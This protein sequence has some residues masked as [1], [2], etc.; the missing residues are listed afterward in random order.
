M[1][2]FL[3]LKWLCFQ[4]KNRSPYLALWLSLGL[5][6]GAVVAAA[7]GSALDS[8]IPA[9]ADQVGSL[10]DLLI[11]VLLPFVL[12]AFA[13][14]MGELWLLYP[15]AF[16]KAFLV[17]FLGF[18]VMSVYGSAGWLIRCLL[19]FSECCTLPILILFWIRQLSGQGSRMTVTALAVFAAVLI[20]SLDYCIVSPFLANVIS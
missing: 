17:S 14:L 1:G 12:S 19:L 15:I 3:N 18:G 8:M 6:A 5:I 11:S 7:A 10:S 9:A 16:F 13:A 2:R 4:R 20:G